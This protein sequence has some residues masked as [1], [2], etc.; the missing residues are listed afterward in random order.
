[1]S[2]PPPT[3]EATSSPLS[4]ALGSSTVTS[5]AT[6]PAVGSTACE[7]RCAWTDWLDESYPVPGASGGDFETYANIRAAG[8][9]ICKRPLD[10]ECRAELLPNVPLQELGQVVQ[11]RLGEGL[12]CHNRDQVGR[13]KMCL[14]YHIRVLCCD[15]YSHCPSTLATTTMTP[16]A[17]SPGPT[18]TLAASTTVW[19]PTTPSPTAPSMGHTAAT[20]PCQ[21]ACRW[22]GWLDSDQPLPGRFGGDI[23]TYYHIQDTGGQLCAD[24][25]AIECQAVLFPDVPLE[26]LGQVLRCDVNYGLICRNN[27]QRGG[28]TCLNYHIRVLCCDDYSHCASSAVPEPTSS[29]SS[30]SSTGQ[31]SSQVPGPRT[32]ATH[33]SSPATTRR[34]TVPTTQ[35]VPPSSVT[36]QT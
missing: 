2:L 8:K 5:T 36:T 27:R 9:A 11:C 33:P 7:P 4:T 15:D 13:F 26:Q 29:S 28:Q 10:L 34:V 17:T 32:T 19:S 22:T 14:N 30:S 6:S 12:V 3:T 31:R 20:S 21:P 18:P 1:T 25:E 23:E 24:P 16:R 35:T